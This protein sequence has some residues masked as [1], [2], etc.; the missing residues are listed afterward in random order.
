MCV[1]A[2]PPRNAYLTVPGVVVDYEDCEASDLDIVGEW[3]GY[4]EC[5]DF[6]DPPGVQNIP[7]SLT[8]TKNQDGSYRYIDDTGAEYEGHLCENRFRYKGGY[9]GFS[10]ESGTMVFES[11]TSATK[12]SIYNHLTEH[13]RLRCSDTLY[14]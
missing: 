1:K 5:T 12:T 10:R 14:K 2:T 9:E 6:G 8:I 13:I 3:N 7:V 4:Y 11:S